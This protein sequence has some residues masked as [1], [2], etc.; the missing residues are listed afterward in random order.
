MPFKTFIEPPPVY[1]MH[2]PKTGG[3]SLGKWLRICYG[4]RRYTDLDVLPLG[5]LSTETLK[6][7]SCYHDWHY[8]RGMYELIGRPDLPSVTLLRDPVER[9]VSEFYERLRAAKRHPAHYRKEYLDIVNAAAD[10]TFDLCLD[11]EFVRRYLTNVQTTCLGRRQDFAPYLQGGSL[12]P[13]DESIFLRPFKWFNDIDQTPARLLTNSHAWLDAMAAVGLTERYDDS[14]LLIADLLGL[15]LPVHLTPSNINPQRRN[16]SMRYRDQMPPAVI[17]Y[18]E[19]I[20][21]FDLELYAHARELF[22]QQW[23]RYQ[24][25]PRRTYSMAPRLRLP[26][27]EAGSGMKNWLRHH[28]PGMWVKMQKVRAQHRAARTEKGL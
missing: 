1:F 9:T 17:A 20:N 26:V 27:N 25:R 8:G 11:H 14:V 12:Q 7:F 19:E 21:R 3:T 5:R 15:P 18:L 2:I 10:K 24:A 4:Q 23:A 28:C 22:K 6:S 13:I 16:S